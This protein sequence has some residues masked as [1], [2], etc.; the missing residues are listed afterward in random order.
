MAVSASLMSP[1]LRHQP[2]AHDEGGSLNCA[3]REARFL[4]G[5]RNHL[6]W[7]GSTGPRAARVSK[8]SG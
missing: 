4:I 2:N 8:V 3:N 7:I 1:R 6:I 5:V